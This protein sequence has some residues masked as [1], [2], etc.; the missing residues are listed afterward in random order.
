MKKGEKI[1][2]SASEFAG[3]KMHWDARMDHLRKFWR[4]IEPKFLREDGISDD[5]WHRQMEDELLDFIEQQSLDISEWKAKGGILPPQGA[6]FMSKWETLKYV[7]KF[8][9]VFI[10]FYDFVPPDEDPAKH[11]TT[12]FVDD[13]ANFQ[14]GIETK[15]I[16]LI[17]ECASLAKQIGSNSYPAFRDALIG[18]NQYDAQ[19]KCDAIDA[20]LKAR[21]TLWADL[22]IWIYMH[23]GVGGTQK[24]QNATRNTKNKQVSAHDGQM[25][26]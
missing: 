17:M 11:V 15:C 1:A 23:K 5:E 12:D 21:L 19:K 14:N 4:E 16:T 2:K 18:F 13:V 3:V 22:E 7:L 8:D 20:M 25:A 10:C 6:T 9:N 26:P 24:R